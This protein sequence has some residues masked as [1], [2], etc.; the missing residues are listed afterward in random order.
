MG[1]LKGLPIFISTAAYRMHRTDSDSKSEMIVR[2]RS[3]IS[4][5]EKNAMAATSQHSNAGI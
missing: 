1:K 4:L 3:E 2:V 5:K